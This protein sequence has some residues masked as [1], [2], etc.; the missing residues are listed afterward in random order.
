METGIHEAL[1]SG[2]P[3]SLD[4][5]FGAVITGLSNSAAWKVVIRIENSVSLIGGPRSVL[6]TARFYIVWAVIVVVC[7]SYVIIVCAI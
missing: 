3:A 5:S 7:Y 2:R 4:Y 6:E 1:A